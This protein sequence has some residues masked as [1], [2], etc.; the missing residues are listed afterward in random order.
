LSD[1]VFLSP[2]TRAPPGTIHRGVASKPAASNCDHG[3][4]IVPTVSFAIRR[5][6]LLSASAQE[7][8]FYF[9]LT[10]CLV[11][12]QCIEGQSSR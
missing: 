11:I 5:T 2:E 1:L 10:R 7:F 4:S 12:G 6:L 8:V 3:D 9:D